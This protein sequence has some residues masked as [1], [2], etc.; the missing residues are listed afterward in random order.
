MMSLL[1][2]LIVILGLVLIAGLGYYLYSTNGTLALQQN[3]QDINL[4]LESA[5]LIRKID[6]IK[7]TSIDRN[8]F[9]DPRFTSLRS[10]ATPIPSYPAGRENPF[11]PQ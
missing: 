7:Q 8:L 11:A 2:N 1:K 6:S 3:E 10:F 9:S 4:Q 5:E